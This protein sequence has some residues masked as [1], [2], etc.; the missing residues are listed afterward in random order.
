MNISKALKEKNRLVGQ[1]NKLKV[2]I[3]RENSR[4]NDNVSQV[5]FE[6]TIK[7]FNSTQ[8]KLVE[9]K[10]AIAIA[11]APIS[12]K[13]IQMA[14]LKATIEFYKTIPIREGEEIVSIGY[15]GDSKEY[16]WKSFINQ[17]K[18]DEAI[19]FFEKLINTLQDQIDEYNAITQI[20]LE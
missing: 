3:Q 15:K 8:D 14:E 5:D 17:Q 10:T 1:L 9:L 13:L 19:S 20:N 2:I 6:K 18:V 12:E 7:E 4:R 16:T 11:T